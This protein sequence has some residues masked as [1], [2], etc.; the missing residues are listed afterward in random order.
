MPDTAHRY[1][2]LRARLHFQQRTAA[3]DGMGGT[4]PGGAFA[5]VFT[6]FA[7][8]KPRLGTEAVTAAR[9]EGRQPWVVTVRDDDRM[10]DVTPAW[11]LV[12]AADPRRVFAI[13]APPIDP[14][15]KRQWVE[16]LVMEPGRS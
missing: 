13:V 1:G 8:M 10:A 14:D 2:A 12:D 5:T 11:Q 7:N 15:G 16:L 3:A 6:R 9:L 4:V